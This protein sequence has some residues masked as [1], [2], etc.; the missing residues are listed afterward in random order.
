M[1]INTSKQFP[2]GAIVFYQGNEGRVVGYTANFSRVR[3]KLTRTRRITTVLP[4][5]LKSAATTAR[6]ESTPVAA[7]ATPQDGNYTIQHNM[8]LPVRNSPSLYQKTIEAVRSM[9]PNDGIEFKEEDLKSFQASV[10]RLRKEDPTRTYTVRRIAN[11]GKWGIW[12]LA[13]GTQLYN[14]VK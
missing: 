8:P 6:L 11:N 4:D 5:N 14:R 1:S 3:V 12:R 10:A 2:I 7:V 9:R 13:D